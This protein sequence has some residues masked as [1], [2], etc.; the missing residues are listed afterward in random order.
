MESQ[1]VFLFHGTLCIGVIHMS[2]FINNS[3]KRQELLKEIIQKIHNG[4]PLEEAKKL[5]KTHF[6][7]VSTEEITRMEQSLIEDGMPVDEVQR[8]C[9]VHA[10]VFDGSISDIHK[11]NDASEIPGHPL[12]VLRSE[13]ERIVKLIDEEIMPY[14]D[15][16][17]KH[18]QLMLRVG[19]ERLSEVDHHYSRKENLFFP[20]LE[21][22]G[23]TSVSKVMWG[24]DN[25]IRNEIKEVLH[26]LSQDSYEYESLQ[27]KMKKV[28]TKVKDMVTKE[29]NILIPML[30]ENID[31]Y[32]F[33]KIDMA[34]KEMNYF[35]HPPKEPWVKDPT[36][37]DNEL[38]EEETE[39]STEE[40]PMDAG[41]LSPVEVNAIFNTVP[42]DM[43][44]VDKDGIVKY[45]TQGEE[46]IFDRPKTIIGRHVNMC[47]PPQSVHIVEEIVKRFETGESDHEDFWI[48][49]ND[50][51][52]HIRY[53][54][55]RDKDNAFLGTLEVT[56]DIKPLRELS[57]EK[58]LLD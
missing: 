32:G 42:L 16:D 46:R 39:T 11:Q 34:S 15:E 33:I 48:Q 41:S 28:I 54:A 24:V 36:D 47:H 45:F 57:G 43:T 29:N 49:M 8:L 14:I 5:F 51:F 37:E 26:L 12:H 55:V 13:N 40:V 17:T 52:V 22:A 21:K 44:F 56:Q 2:E 20:Y 53:Y 35:I 27:D 9:D 7:S 58:R 25:E 19:F 31:F 3:E 23:I 30:K 38:S 18:N 6:E 1:P 50:A 4:M 10:S